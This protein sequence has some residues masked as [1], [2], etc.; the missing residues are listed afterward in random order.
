MGRMTKLLEQAVGQARELS[1]E[2]QDA[3]A[4]VLFAHIANEDRRYGLSMEQVKEVRRIRE[5][6]QSGET[7]LATEDEMQTLWKKCGA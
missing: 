3:A 5:R 1:A 6:L 4:D 7:R 2:D